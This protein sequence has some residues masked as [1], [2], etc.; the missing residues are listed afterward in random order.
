MTKQNEDPQK[1]RID[2]Y[3]W[4]IRV[5]KTRTLAATAC[6]NGK[7]SC[8]GLKV[9]AS[10]T[11]KMK[12]TYTIKISGEVTR[13]VEVKALLEKRE[14]AEKVKPYFIDHSPAPEAK[15]KLPS[16]FYQPQGKRERGSGRPSKKEGRDLRGAFGFD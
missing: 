2:K 9:K 13:I 5:F 15:E 12:D 14:S 8:K 16:V 11:V 10:Y 7:V 3:L 4:A 6:D 1:V